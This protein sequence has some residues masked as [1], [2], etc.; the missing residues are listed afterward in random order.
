MSYAYPQD[1]TRD[2]QT[3]GEQPYED[4]RQAMAETEDE[5]PSNAERYSEEDANARPRM[6]EDEAEAQAADRLKVTQGDV[7]D[8]RAARDRQRGAD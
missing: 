2:R 5:I 7:A 4:A 6:S 1:R 8:E 3:K